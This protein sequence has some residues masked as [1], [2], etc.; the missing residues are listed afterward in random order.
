LTAAAA[1]IDWYSRPFF[2]AA[3]TMRAMRRQQDDAMAQFLDAASPEVS[4]AAG[5]H[6]HGGRR[7]V[8]EE[9]PGRR[10]VY[11]DAALGIEEVGWSDTK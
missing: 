10:L 6:D 7:V 2:H 4:G 9:L 8:G 1:G 11:L 3:H 5:L